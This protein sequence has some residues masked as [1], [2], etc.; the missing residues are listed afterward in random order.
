M[1]DWISQNWTHF[2]TTTHI[3][4]LEGV[5]VLFC[6]S[7]RRSQSVLEMRHKKWSKNSQINP[8]TEVLEAPG[9]LPARTSTQPKGLL[10]ARRCC[11]HLVLQQGLITSSRMAK[12]RSGWQ[13]FR[14]TA[15]LKLSASSKKERVSTK[16]KRLRHP[17]PLNF[18]CLS[19]Y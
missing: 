3:S 17:L 12:T 13:G 8:A 14:A 10:S 6:F 18:S 11:T 5:L 4:H 9:T 1:E 7:S 16:P 2:R 15:V 19:P